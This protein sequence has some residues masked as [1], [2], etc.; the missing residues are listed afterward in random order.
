MDWD[1]SVLD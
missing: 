1:N